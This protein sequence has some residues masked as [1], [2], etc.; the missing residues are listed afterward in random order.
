MSWK[1][2]TE[3]MHMVLSSGQFAHLHNSNARLSVHQGLCHTLTYLVMMYLD[4]LPKVKDTKSGSAISLQLVPGSGR[5]KTNLWHHWLIGYQCMPALRHS[6]RFLVEIHVVCITVS[7]IG[8]ESRA[9]ILPQVRSW[10]PLKGN[11]NPKWQTV[12]GLTKR[13]PWKGSKRSHQYGPQHPGKNG[14]RVTL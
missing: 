3:L 14:R 9:G 4:L 6:N 11:T 12:N 1:Q 8:V 7:H 2:T 5:N 10:F 13:V